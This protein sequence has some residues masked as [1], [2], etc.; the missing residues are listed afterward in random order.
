MIERLAGTGGMSSVYRALDQRSG[1]VVA[2]KQLA[3]QSD[4]GRFAR[5]IQILASLEHD[6]IV[7]YVAHGTSGGGS[8]LAMEWLEG[9]DL[10][11]RLVRGPLSIDDAIALVTRIAGA[12]GFAHDLS[13][14]H[15]DLKPSNVFL[16]GGRIEGVKL[17]DFG[18]A[19]GLGT[20]VTRS[21]ALLGT[22][23]YMAP[24]Q[25]TSGASV[26][27]RSDV[28]ALGC[29][30]FESITGRAAFRGEHVMAVLAKILFEDSPR[31]HEHLRDAPPWLDLLVA[32]LLAKDP[33][34]RPRDGKAVARLLGI[35]G[36]D[37]TLD[38]A[39]EPARESSPS[40]TRAEQRYVSVLIASGDVDIASSVEV[41]KVL[42][43]DGSIDTISQVRGLLTPLPARVQWL[44]DGSVVC[45]LGELGN[46]SDQARLAARCALA[47]RRGR[48]QAAISI[49]TGRAELA[50]KV[51]IGEAIDRAAMLSR[52]GDGVGVRLDETTA[53]LLGP[54]FLV[55]GDERGLVLRGEREDTDHVRTLL[56]KP[57]TCVGRDKEL[58]FLLALYEECR[59]EA[60][61]RAVLVAG[62]PGIGK[63]RLRNE[64]VARFRGSAVDARIWLGGSDPLTA[65]SP[66][67]TLARLLRH[68][69]GLQSGEP[70][71]VHE[72]KI[73]ARVGRRFGEVEQGRIAPFLGELA[74][75]PFC[76]DN[77]PALRAARGDPRLLGDRMQS[78]WL[79]LL[80]AECDAGPLAIMLEDLHW[81][82]RGTVE[83]IDLALRALHD[84]PL[85]VIAFAR[86]EI[87][88]TFPRLWAERELHTVRLAALTPRA[89]ERLVREV[90]DDATP[91]RA[92]GTLDDNAI[93]AIVRQAAG[94][95]FFLEE[96]IRAHVAGQ[97][98]QLPAT[99]MAVAQ[100][101]LDAVDA[102]SRRTMR[103]ASVLGEVFWV[104]AV[105]AMLGDDRSAVDRLEQLVAAELLQDR[106]TGR[107]IGEHELAFRH[108]LV[109]EAA[110][111]TLTDADRTLGHRLAGEWLERAGEPEA[112]VLAEHFERGDSP[113]RAA[114]HYL[115]AAEQAYESE[116]LEAALRC[117]TRGL[118]CTQDRATIGALRLV[119]ASVHDWRGENLEAARLGREAMTLLP[120][121]PAWHLAATCVAVVCRRMGARDDLVA[122]ANELAALSPAEV[123][124]SVE[125]RCLGRV[126]VQL[127]V[128]GLRACATAL[129]D[130]I[131]R[132]EAL[133]PTTEI[134]ARLWIW[135]CRGMFARFE[136]DLDVLLDDGAH[137]IALADESGDLRTAVNLRFY[138]GVAALGVGEPATAEREFRA[139]IAIAERLAIPTM[140][141]TI[142]N[143]LCATLI[144]LGQLDEARELADRALDEATGLGD[145][146]RQSL[147]HQHLARVLARS[148]DLEQAEHHARQA[149]ATSGAAPAFR[150]S[151]LGTL[152]EVQLW[153][154]QPQLALA[155]AREAIAIER[156]DTFQYIDDL[157]TLVFAEALH[158]CKL[159]DEARAAIADA[160]D[161]L[162]ATASR[163][164]GTRA[165]SYLATTRSRRIL[166]RAAEWTS[167]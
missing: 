49:A 60:V 98:T 144:E 104:G 33:A 89:A 24:E 52:R 54:E 53:G 41:A 165:A 136:G 4:P 166:A 119:E 7:R 70:H 34:H 132:S 118:A 95:A 48:P 86:P 35:A 111:G 80:R 143:D 127:I 25:A 11:S 13:I 73:R 140:V 14:V 115:R 100:A 21:G 26:D 12:V 156:A 5:E 67:G 36:T 85:L 117:S 50:G 22:P 134:R 164:K 116:D 133:V 57:T 15:R 9:E 150:R 94:N 92:T 51:P 84:R 58:G 40:L 81:G 2:L 63:S 142:R 124:G 44:V 148:G 130:L 16:P 141:S 69:F 47:L 32:K 20:A 123:T 149:R 154:G 137:M 38:A 135:A 161:Q 163:L 158:G 145:G 122:V 93:T 109:R 167:R 62:A 10:A 18:I 42:G 65:G 114:A 103:A 39:V 88:T 105:V 110:Y 83:Y 74:G 151:I 125:R 3:P 75:V 96:L 59:Q 79:D 146:F 153:R 126:T 113:D 107:F 162:V 27:A 66:L 28:F 19:R 129:L 37:I 160:H 155:V 43:G 99:V 106:G 31:L 131:A 76:D 56:G 78:A 108:A 97:A 72:R 112:I 71:E 82:D 91:D 55:G 128:V 121:G 45:V 101:R 152:A 138:V 29:V 159:V 139:A 90:L 8:Y 6:A 23:G 120:H 30:L 17:L 77:D 157:S 61:S 46:A 147:A 68:E 64:L 1:G 87:A 102:E